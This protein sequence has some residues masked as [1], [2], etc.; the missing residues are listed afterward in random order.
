MQFSLRAPDVARRVKKSFR[1]TSVFQLALCAFALV[2]IPLIIGLMSATWAVD[3]LVAKSQQ[4]V[5][6]GVQVID[7]GRAMVEDITAMER[8]ARQFALLGDHELLEA[9]GRRRENFQRSVEVLRQRDFAEKDPLDA[10]ISAERD[11][12][13]AL[14]GFP[15]DSQEVA[16]AIALFPRMGDDVRRVLADSSRAIGREIDAMRRDADRTQRVL[17]RQ[18]LAV[19]PAAL[20]LALV[21]TLLITRPVRQVDN[22]IRRLG[23]GHF[24]TPIR[25]R[26]PRDLQELGQ[27]LDWLRLRL[28]DLDAQKIRFLRHISHELKTPLAAIR[29]GAQLLSDEVA[30]DLK[31]AQ[32][33]IAGILVASTIQLQRRIEDLLSFNT[34]VQG[35]GVPAL[36]ESIDIRVLLDTVLEDHAG[37]IEARDLVVEREVG[38][39]RITGDREQLR[40]VLDNLLSNAI[41]YSPSG[42]RIR[43]GM[44]QQGDKAVIQVR[45]EGPGIDPAERDMIFQPFFQGSALHDG[46][47]RGT[48]LG[49]AITLE[50][51]RAHH[52]TIEV[53]EVARGAC[54]Q[55]RLPLRA[56]MVTETAAGSP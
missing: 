19:I 34:I 12:Y 55:V 5:R 41:K 37:D 52:G 10:L 22:A 9:Y 13:A 29:E 8:N 39:H 36:R 40:V 26:G 21:G 48:G 33:E 46:H 50:Y 42:G 30:G 32:A 27:R 18:A 16:A 11:A 15:P 44:Q 3:E 31:P 24:E 17:T 25:V 20:I 53:A 38:V 6:E 7:A 4:S 2:G 35:L 54:L 49:L 28:L 45:D 23:R 1:P 56:G 47:V 51:V 14:T 43:V